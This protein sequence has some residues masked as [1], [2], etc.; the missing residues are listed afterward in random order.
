MEQANTKGQTFQPD[1]MIIPATKRFVQGGSQFLKQR[2]LRV[3]AYCRVSTGDE[4]QQTSYSNQ[5]AFYAGLIQHR[6][7]WSFAG[8]YADEAR[9]GTNRIHRKEFNRMMEDA[10]AG[11]IDYIMTKSISRFARNTIDTLE[12]VRQLRALSPP[13]GIVFEKE[14][15][16]TLNA[17]GELILTILSALAQDES[18]SLSDNIR[19]TFQKN[20]QAGKPQINLNRML[21]YD[22]G[23]NGAWEINEEQAKTVRFL[24]GKY[25]AGDSANAVAKQAN[26]AGLRTVNGKLWRADSVIDILR[27]E[28]F[29]GDLEMQK[30]VT[31][32]FLTHK[33][34]VNNGEAPKYYVR[35]HH[36]GIIDRSAWEKTQLML[37]M[38]QERREKTAKG[39]SPHAPFGNLV[40][41][42]KVMGKVCGE[43]FFRLT[44][45]AAAKGYQDDRSR[46]FDPKSETEVYSFQYPVWRCGRKRGEKKAPGGSV[47]PAA[48]LREC[49]L[50]Q[51]FMEMLY[52][53]KRDY[54]AKGR[55]SFLAREFQRVW[56][57]GTLPPQKCDRFFPHSEGFPEE[58]SA[59]DAAKRN[60]DFFLRCLME[61]PEKNSA[62]MKLRV[63]GLDELCSELSDLDTLSTAE[64]IDR[65]PDFLRFERGIYAAFMES[66]VV[67]GD[68][69]EYTTN[70]GVRLI[71]IGNAR[72]LKGFLGWRKS[73]ED[74]TVE[75]L[76]EPWKV[77]AKTIT[78]VR[79]KRKRIQQ[80]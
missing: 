38:K 29:V 77:N 61:L 79:K 63:N 8:I 68:L 3:A 23:E 28:K 37:G 50:E 71:S 36:E 19:W 69:I 44:Y 60:F 56:G 40:C 46:G 24:Y 41:G 6:P 33:S 80:K 39:A 66:G 2:S 30:T 51:S 12:C 26:E 14:N 57:K 47:C 27:N 7:G 53:L 35:D 11:K 55:E 22:K 62:G 58:V 20:F 34:C 74:G 25:L 15:I 13:V 31:K 48:V 1:V 49:A 75:L 59:L 32:D 42:E 5:R 52:G 21:G 4:S 10:K 73:R 65:A 78:Y 9:S 17:T 45:W 64:I 67:N 72:T 18:R 16:D 76:D 43:R 54:L 70:F